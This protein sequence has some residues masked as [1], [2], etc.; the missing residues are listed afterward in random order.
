MKLEITTGATSVG[1]KATEVYVFNLDSK[2]NSARVNISLTSTGIHQAVN[3]YNHY[4]SLTI[5]ESYCII[6]VKNLLRSNNYKDLNYQLVTEQVTQAEFESELENHPD[7]Y[8]NIE[9]KPIA[10]LEHL[11]VISG[12]M[13]KVDVDLS[14]DEVA[15]MFS[16]TSKSI[17]EA[18]TNLKYLSK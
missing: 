4:I 5:Q 16:V 1:S 3:Q 2:D 17:E 8:Y 15:D 10:S 12:I 14:I 18:S 9:S 11:H 7:K 13:R 6:A